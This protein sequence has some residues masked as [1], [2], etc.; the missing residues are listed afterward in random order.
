MASS[1][2]SGG[3]WVNARKLDASHPD[4]TGEINVDGN[5]IKI[6]AWLSKSTNPAAPYINIKVNDVVRA[7]PVVPKS[8]VIDGIDFDDDIPF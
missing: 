1:I 4:Y 5:A 2:N 3:L 6:V 7:V 8:T